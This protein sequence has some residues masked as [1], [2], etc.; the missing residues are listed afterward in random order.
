MS[1]ACL[2]REVAVTTPTRGDNEGIL[3]LVNSINE[4]VKQIAASQEQ[5]RA[6][7]LSQIDELRATI[8]RREEYRDNLDGVKREVATIST[9]V[10][11]LESSLTEKIEQ[12]GKESKA[13]Q[14]ANYKIVIRIQAAILVF[15]IST[16]VGIAIKVFIH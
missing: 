16:I 1:T 3:L 15:I 8:I 11:R 14:E 13:Q 4:Q 5:L 10:D 7:L 9:K 6:Y 12:V 2:E